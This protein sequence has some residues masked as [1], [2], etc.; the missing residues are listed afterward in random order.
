MIDKR[1]ECKRKMQLKCDDCMDLKCKE[2]ERGCKGFLNDAAEWI[3][4]RVDDV[5]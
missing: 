2:A 5:G 1:E 4:G 3:G